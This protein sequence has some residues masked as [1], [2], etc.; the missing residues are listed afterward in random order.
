MTVILQVQSVKRG[1]CID[2]TH[3]VQLIAN[4][5]VAHGG[6]QFSFCLRV[7]QDVCISIALFHVE[8]SCTRFVIVLHDV[9]T[10]GK[11]SLLTTDEHT[12]AKAFVACRGTYGTIVAVYAL[13]RLSALTVHHNVQHTTHALGIILRARVGH[14]LNALHGNGRHI[15]E[16]HRGV[17]REHHIG[18]AVHIHLERRRAV[19]RD[20]VLTVYR[21]HGHL[22]EHVEHGVRLRVLVFGYVVAHLV[23]LHLHQ[24]LL[25]HHFHALQHRIAVLN[26]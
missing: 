2:V 15:L 19:D 18:F 24:W 6:W 8:I 4:R 12:S 3:R 13:C 5:K 16:N 17:R 9:G 26:I 14:H 23:N 11:L 25:S 20:I 1:C 21:H 22:A 10:I 7:Y